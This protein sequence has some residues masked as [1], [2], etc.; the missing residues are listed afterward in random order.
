M[1]RKFRGSKRQAVSYDTNT[2]NITTNNNCEEYSCE[3]CGLDV[4][5][6]TCDEFVGGE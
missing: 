6:C 1:I 4:Q 3:D 2:G 5:A